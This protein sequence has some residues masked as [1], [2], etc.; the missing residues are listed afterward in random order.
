MSDR[1]KLAN[2]DKREC[3]KEKERKKK[4]Q[5]ALA[6]ENGRDEA[7]VC[8]GGERKKW[9]DQGKPGTTGGRNPIFPFSPVSSH[10]PSSGG[11]DVISRFNTQNGGQT[12]NFPLI[13]QFAN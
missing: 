10:A 9:A 12:S 5:I 11:G 8:L 6:T 3:W 7:L 2:F 4:D 13:N 1:A